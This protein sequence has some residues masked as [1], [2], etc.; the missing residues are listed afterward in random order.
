[1]KET[2]SE[3]GRLATGDSPE[4]GVPLVGSRRGP[5]FSLGTLL[6]LMALAAVGVTVWQLYRE[7]V[8]L[9]AELRRFRDEA[10][11]LSIDDPTK[12]HAIRLQSL[13]DST[14]KFRI[15]VPKGQRY[16]LVLTVNDVPRSGL[17]AIWRPQ[18]RPG[19][20]ECSMLGNGNYVFLSEGEHVISVGVATTEE[21]I[22]C[23][24]MEQYD[25]TTGWR[26]K[27]HRV[28]VKEA[29]WPRVDHGGFEEDGLKDRSTH[30]AGRSGEITLMRYIAPQVP[31]QGPPVP[32]SYPADGF[33]LWIEPLQGG[34]KAQR[35]MIMH[36]AEARCARGR[37]I[38]DYRSRLYDGRALG[39]NEYNASRF[40][41]RRPRRIRCRRHRQRPGRADRRQCARPRRPFG[42]AV[43]AALQARRH[44]HLVQAAG[45]AH[46]RYFAARFPRGHDQE[47][48][49]VLD[50]GDRRFDRPTERHPVRQPDV[51]AHHHL[52]SRRFHQAARQSVPRRCAGGR[53]LLRCRA[54]HELLRRPVDDCRRVVRAVLPRTR[55]RYPTA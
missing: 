36:T 51:L 45:R 4:L 25:E 35:P 13:D 26:G 53:W 12:L 20:Y 21:G 22:R 55:R 1:M 28:E 41:P 5:R 11:S 6:L 52:Q 32:V 16:G 48:P 42:A 31:Q 46:L 23:V 50:A 54:K 49:A 3:P 44:G 10:G 37:P 24:S 30:M 47:L 18:P 40:S 8:P 34:G 38:R 7:L 19:R 43:G 17:P 9:R 2:S 15:Y 27:R 33:L 14:W 29:E 39:Y